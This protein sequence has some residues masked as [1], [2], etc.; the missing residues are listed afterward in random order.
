MSTVFGYLL[1][2]A[3]CLSQVGVTGYIFYEYWSIFIN[4][5]EPLFQQIVIA[6]SLVVLLLG[7]TKLAFNWKAFSALLYALAV[8][9]Y[10]LFFIQMAASFYAYTQNGTWPNLEGTLFTAAVTLTCAGY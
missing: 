10:F 7:L 9:N 1:L 5:Q 8:I 6:Q 2:L 4:G 3:G